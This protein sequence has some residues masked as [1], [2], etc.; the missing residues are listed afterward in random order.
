MSKADDD[1]A[2]FYEDPANIR[3]VGPEAAM[4]KLVELTEEL[5]LYDETDAAGEPRKVD[6]GC[7]YCG[8][9]ACTA[10]RAGG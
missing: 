2:A 10:H 1:V 3:F 8:A 7:P 6:A 9:E 4:Q 5:G